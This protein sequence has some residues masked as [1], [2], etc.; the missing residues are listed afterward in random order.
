MLSSGI[1]TVNVGVAGQYTLGTLAVP[2]TT[3]ATAK[4]VNEI[5]IRARN[6]N[7]IGGYNHSSTTKIQV[8]NATPTGLDKEDGGIAVSDS[9]GATHDDDALRITSFSASSGPNPSVS[10]TN[11]YTGSAWSGAVTVAGTYEAITRFGTIGH[12]V[13]DY[14]SGYLPAGPD[15]AT[16]RSGAQ[17]YTFAFRRS[18]L[19]NF[20]LTMSGKVSGM[21]I[22]APGTQIDQTILGIGPTSGLSGWLNCSAV[23]TPGGI[24]GSNTGNGGNGSDGCCYDSGDIVVDNTTYSAQEFTFTLGEENGSNA[25]GNNILVRIKL[26]SGDSI[27]ALAID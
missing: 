20:N 7:G 10:A 6:C 1:P 22:A 8:Y 4:A 23:A 16:S 3:S 24:P 5:K 17:Y 15:L 9:L 11:Y 13:I 12:N 19:P 21:W 27:T 25:T 26:E 2:I 18:N 14:T